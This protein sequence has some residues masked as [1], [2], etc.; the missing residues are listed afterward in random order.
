MTMPKQ[1]WRFSD[2]LSNDVVGVISVIPSRIKGHTM[3]ATVEFKGD[4]HMF[5]NRV[6]SHSKRPFALRINQ[7][8][9][10]M[11]VFDLE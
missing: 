2:F 3:S 7:T 5:I 10:G 11:I 8:Q 1:Y 9:D 4:R 6:L